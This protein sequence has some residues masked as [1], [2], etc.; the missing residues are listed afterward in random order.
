MNHHEI[1]ASQYMASPLQYGTFCYFVDKFHVSLCIYFKKILQGNCIMR[2]YTFFL[3]TKQAYIQF[4]EI[5]MAS[6][7]RMGNL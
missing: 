1:V 3:H 2:D 7:I 6:D 5:C 4:S